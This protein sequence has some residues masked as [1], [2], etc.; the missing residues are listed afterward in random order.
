MLRCEH[1]GRGE[2]LFSD[3]SRMHLPSFVIDADGKYLCVGGRDYGTPNEVPTTIRSTSEPEKVLA[4]SNMK[5]A[6][7]RSYCFDDKLYVCVRHYLPAEDGP[8]SMDC[9]V[10]ERRGDELVLTDSMTIESPLWLSNYVL[11]EDICPDQEHALLRASRDMPLGSCS[12]LL[13]MRIHK[14]SRLGHH[15]YTDD[16]F[17]LDRKVFD[18]LLDNTIPQEP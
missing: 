7:W 17:F 16:V 11:I 12:Y 6:L 15:P 3:G 2:V 1:L 4:V 13:N 18:R 8:T 10:Y 9:E 5:G 14:R